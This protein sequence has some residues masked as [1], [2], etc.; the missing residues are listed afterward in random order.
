MDPFNL[1]PVAA[2]LEL[3]A[4]PVRRAEL[5][6]HSRTVGESLHWEQTLGELREFVARPHRSSVPPVLG[7]A[8]GPGR[9]VASLAGT[10]LR[11]LRAGGPGRVLQLIRDRRR[12]RSLG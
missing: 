9:G 10:A 12:R 8:V 11:A 6:E 3:A 4:D 1:P 7:A 5:A 2:I